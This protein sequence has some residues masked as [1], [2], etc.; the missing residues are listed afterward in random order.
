MQMALSVCLFVRQTKLYL[1]HTPPVNNTYNVLVVM[2]CP[3]QTCLFFST[4]E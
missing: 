3:Q 4:Y 2:A 1:H